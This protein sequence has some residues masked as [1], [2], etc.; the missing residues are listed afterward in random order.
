[1]RVMPSFQNTLSSMRA[2]W[3]ACSRG[4]SITD[5]KLELKPFLLGLSFCQ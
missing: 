1:M 4:K 3:M 5:G 2:V